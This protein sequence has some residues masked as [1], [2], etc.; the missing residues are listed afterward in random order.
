MSMSVLVTASLLAASATFAQPARIVFEMAALEDGNTLLTFRSDSPGTVKRVP[1]GSVDGDLVAIDVR[2]A[3]GKLYGLTT[4]QTLLI[5]DVATGASRVVSRLG[6]PFDGG[7]I[8]GMDFNPQADRLRLVAPDGQNLRINVA[9]GAVAIDGPLHY[10]PDDE[11][12]GRKPQ[13]SA[14]GYTNSVARASR[15]DTFAIDHDRDVLVRQEP[16]ND[17]VLTTVGR[18]GV[19]CDAVNGFDIAIDASGIDHAFM[20]CG[21]VLYSLDL[22]TGAAAPIGDLGAGEKRV[23]TG[24]AVL[25]PA[26]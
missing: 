5:L 19:D 24:L 12:A 2:P 6:S 16:P 3:D 4:S 11:H 22:R 26:R 23:I 9:V 8:A 7:R 25:G 10:G 17:G 1:L 18:L 20:V 14:S 13:V 21:A 15:T